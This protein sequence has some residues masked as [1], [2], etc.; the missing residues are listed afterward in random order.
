MCL[1]LY[2]KNHTDLLACSTDP[3]W[4]LAERQ[5]VACLTE[6]ATLLLKERKDSNDVACLTEMA[7]LRL[8][9]RKDSKDTFTPRD[10]V[11]NF[12]NYYSPTILGV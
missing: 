2:G 7:T 8:K 1:L 3:I 6:M 9:E 10:T 5:H 4:E 12:K 11:C